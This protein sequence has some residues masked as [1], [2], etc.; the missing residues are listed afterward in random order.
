MYLLKF[1]TNSEIFK[2][3]WGCR[4]L[5]GKKPAFSDKIMIKCKVHFRIKRFV[6]NNA[7]NAENKI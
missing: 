3:G 7:G 5:I 2:H 4:N 1:E 6:Q